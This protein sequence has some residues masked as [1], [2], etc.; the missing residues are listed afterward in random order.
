VQIPWLT[1]TESPSLLIVTT[2]AGDTLA[3]LQ[4]LMPR[5]PETTPVVLFQNGLGSQQRVAQIWPS[6]PI[7]AATTT[8]GANR[9]ETELTVHAG[10]GETWVGA[11]TSA[12]EARLRKTVSTLADSGL[13]VIATPDILDRLWQK[14]VI[15]AGINPF[16]AI[17]NCPNGEILAHSFYQQWID[18]LCQEISELL[19][20]SGQAPR[21]ATALKDAIETIARNTAAN[22]SSMRADRLAGRKTEIDFINGYLARLGAELSIDT[23]VNQMLADQ[24]EQLN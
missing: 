16:T 2:K 23:P 1:N 22:T 21:S 5:L 15:N 12:G 11:V 3:A 14:L 7:L 8:E 18:P 10:Q 20:A 9:P 24:V 4:P 6:H 17:L 19:T 13:S